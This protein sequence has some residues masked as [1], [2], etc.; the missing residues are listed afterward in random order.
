M[1]TVNVPRNMVRPPITPHKTC[2]PRLMPP[3]KRC[4]P[5]SKSPAKRCDPRLNFPAKRCDPRLN[6]PAI[7]GKIPVF[8]KYFVAKMEKYRF[9]VRGTLSGG[10]AAGVFK[11][12]PLNV[13]TFVTMHFHLSFQIVPLVSV[14]ALH[15]RAG[16]ESEGLRCA[17][18]K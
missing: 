10:H 15:A 5:R 1:T 4:D 6:S 9:F 12:T 18:S 14:V 13:A 7:Y 2:D 8:S 17:R 3:A 16:R 11:I